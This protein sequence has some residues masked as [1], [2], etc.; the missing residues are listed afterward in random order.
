MEQIVKKVQAKFML[1]PSTHDRIKEV[2]ASEGVSASK[3][4]ENLVDKYLH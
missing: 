3:L 1:P 2:A 4:V